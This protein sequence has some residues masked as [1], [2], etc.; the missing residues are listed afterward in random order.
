MPFFNGSFKKPIFFLGFEITKFSCLILF[1]G[2]TQIN[3]SPIF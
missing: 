1:F 2:N 3:D